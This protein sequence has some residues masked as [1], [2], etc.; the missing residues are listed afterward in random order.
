MRIGQTAVASSGIAECK[1]T[2]TLS[3]V[4]WLAW[5]WWDLVERAVEYM[6][7]RALSTRTRLRLR[8][9]RFF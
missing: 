7:W 3:R 6:T 4:C 9:L 8:L 1:K 2:L 5:R